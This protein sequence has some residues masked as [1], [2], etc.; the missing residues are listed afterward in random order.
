MKK[1]ILLCLLAL[2][3]CYDP[4]G[5]L[6]A[7]DNDLKKQA[8]LTTPLR[9]PRQCDSACTLYLSDAQ[10]CIPRNGSIGVHA[11]AIDGFISEEATR[12]MFNH[13]WRFPLFQEAII[14]DK[15][16]ATFKI[17]VYTAKQMNS[18]GVPYCV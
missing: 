2:A 10:V 15:A 11:G 6:V 7:R 17:K 18:F 5:E 12:S 3:G 9:L 1:S 4:G 16:M 8:A 14:R 13:Y